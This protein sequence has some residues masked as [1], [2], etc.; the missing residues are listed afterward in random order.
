MFASLTPTQKKVAVGV[1][2]G[3]VA[4]AALWFFGK[5]AA[6]AVKGMIAPDAEAP[7]A[8]AAPTETPA[9]EAPAASA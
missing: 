9:P 7:P 6:E 2:V 1:A 3:V 4:G 5:D 8:D